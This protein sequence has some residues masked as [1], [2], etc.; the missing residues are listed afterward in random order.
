MVLNGIS[1]LTFREAFISLKFSYLNC[2]STCTAKKE[3]VEEEGGKERRKHLKDNCSYGH[4]IGVMSDSLMGLLYVSSVLCISMDYLHLLLVFDTF[5][6][7]QKS[8]NG[9]FSI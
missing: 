8:R 4:K 3:R 2:L 1:P 6:Q 5:S 7:Q 9:D